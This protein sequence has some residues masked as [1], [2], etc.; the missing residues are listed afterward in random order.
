MKEITTFLEKMRGRYMLGFRPNRERIKGQMVK[1]KVEL[2]PPA[3]KKNKDAQ[4]R[5]R[6]GYVAAA[7]NKG[8]W[9]QNTKDGVRGLRESSPE[10][11]AESW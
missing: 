10:A 2:S 5:H 1:I 8:E 11:L 7:G 9:K 4:L 3:R 6:H